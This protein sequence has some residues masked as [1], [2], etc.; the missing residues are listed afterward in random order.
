MDKPAGA[1]KGREDFDVQSRILF[2]EQ[3]TP[4]RHLL[5]RQALSQAALTA[6]G[7][8]VDF[9]ISTSTKSSSVTGGQ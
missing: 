4:A 9:L 3:K 2:V 6:T 1:V 8:D 7:C 5:M